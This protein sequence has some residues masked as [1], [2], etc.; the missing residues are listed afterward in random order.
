MGRL[1]LKRTGLAQ[2]QAE[3]MKIGDSWILKKDY[4]Q[5]LARI[6]RDA[7]KKLDADVMH[8]ARL[9]TA[10]I[11]TNWLYGAFALALHRAYGWGPIRIA[12]ALHATDDVAGEIASMS[13]RDIW[14]LVSQE[15]NVKFIDD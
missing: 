9:E 14:D 15:T 8:K 10:E 1:K 4:Q 3:R 6:H 12:R 13:I 5:F 7:T 11:Q 2:P